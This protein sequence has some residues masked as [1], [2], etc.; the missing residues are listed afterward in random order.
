MVCLDE[1]NSD[2]PGIRD[3]RWG[4]HWKRANPFRWNFEHVLD[5]IGCDLRAINEP[6]GPA[7]G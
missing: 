6:I 3:F 5:E 1:S 7:G 2:A 4:V